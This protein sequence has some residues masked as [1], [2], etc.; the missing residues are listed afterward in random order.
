MKALYLASSG[1]WRL[2]LTV[3]A[4][5]L[6]TAEVTARIMA[7]CEAEFADLGITIVWW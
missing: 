5:L 6:T 2:V 3:S 1:E 4:A 7:E